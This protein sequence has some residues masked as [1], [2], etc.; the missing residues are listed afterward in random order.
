[1]V[2]LAPAA[3]LDPQLFAN[4]N[5]EAFAPLTLMLVMANG[6]LPMLVKVT[7][8]EALSVPTFWMP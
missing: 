1:M 8:C 7:D 4:A 2:P 6:T 5:E 3:R